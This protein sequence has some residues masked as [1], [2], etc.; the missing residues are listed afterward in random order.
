MI[1]RVDSERQLQRF[2]EDVQNGNAE[3]EALLIY[4]RFLCYGIKYDFC[5]FF[6]AADCVLNELYQSYVIYGDADLDELA[7]FFSFCAFKEIVCSYDVGRALSDKL[8]LC[9]RSDVNLMRFGG[10]GVPYEIEK[11]VALD[12]FYKI[13][14]TGFEIDFESW[15]LETSHRIRH[16][17]SRLRRLENS[18]LAIQYD[19]YGS[20]LISQVATAPESRGKGDASRLI[21]SVCSELAPSEVY[22]LCEDKLVDFYKR[23]G[24]EFVCKKCE[25]KR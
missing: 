3:P 17:I 13:L 16:N 5:R 19:M 11:N 12:E 9:R 25:L 4:E 10:I 8:Q 18:V 14:K 23:I 21:L 22:L 24:F 15:Y 6:K 2:I 7:Q 1:K 20:A